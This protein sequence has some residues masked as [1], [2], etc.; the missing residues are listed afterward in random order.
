MTG[1]GAAGE[2]HG[3]IAYNDAALLSTLAIVDI[4][5]FDFASLGE[6]RKVKIRKE[7]NR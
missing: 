4:A 3:K 5:L 7:R 2:E 6:L 1:S